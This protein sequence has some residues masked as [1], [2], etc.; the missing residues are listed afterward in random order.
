MLGTACLGRLSLILESDIISN[1]YLFHRRHMNDVITTRNGV[2]A[3]F[4]AR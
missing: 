3:T 1:F 2:I 4:A